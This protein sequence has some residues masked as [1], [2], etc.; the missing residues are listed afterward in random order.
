MLNVNLP[1][2]HEIMWMFRHTGQRGSSHGVGSI[3][4]RQDPRSVDGKCGHAARACCLDGAKRPALLLR[5]FCRPWNVEAE[6]W[7][8]TR[9]GVEHEAEGEIS[10]ESG[11]K[12]KVPMWHL[13]LEMTASRTKVVDW[14]MRIG[15]ARPDDHLPF[16]PSTMLVQTT[17][18]DWPH[19]P[20]Q[21]PLTLLLRVRSVGPRICPLTVV[22]AACLF[23][24]ATVSPGWM[25][26]W[27]LRCLDL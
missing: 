4:S 5:W 21:A 20:P 23:D 2:I 10:I 1:L 22:D 17:R 6:R 25:A 16:R 19:G 3:A 11:G 8:T 7:T 15:G 27:D 9:R 13:Q 18:A 24:F 26:V 14:A 12:V